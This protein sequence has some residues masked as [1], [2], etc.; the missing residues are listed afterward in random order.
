VFNFL[1]PFEFAF[2][3]ES[4]LCNDVFAANECIRLCDIEL[5]DVDDVEVEVEE[6]EEAIR[7]KEVVLDLGIPLLAIEVSTPPMVVVVL[8]NGLFKWDVNPIALGGE[9]NE[10]VLVRKEANPV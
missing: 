6:E 4:G 10:V 2:G 1:F 7:A 5:D 3:V 9:I 8:P